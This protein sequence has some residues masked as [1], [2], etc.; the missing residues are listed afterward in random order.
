AADKAG[1]ITT[2]AI[3]LDGK[4]T[5]PDISNVN[6]TEDQHID[7][8]ASVKIEFDSEAGARAKFVV[9]M[10]LTDSGN[11]QNA[12]ELRMM[13]TDDGHYVGYWTATKNA[14]AEGAV[15]EVIIEDD[16][17]NESREQADGRLFI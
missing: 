7:A 6:P 11:L 1:N 10:A 3:T 15:I 12:V 2:E 8:G 16:Y 13:E 9:H 4:Y 5:A 17:G 14:Y